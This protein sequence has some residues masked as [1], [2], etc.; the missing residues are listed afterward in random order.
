MRACSTWAAARPRSDGGTG[1][2]DDFYGKA[3]ALVPIRA[4]IRLP[5]HALTFFNLA[6]RQILSW[7]HGIVEEIGIEATL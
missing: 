5:I 6:C 1:F 3:Y 7:T 4:Y 2:D